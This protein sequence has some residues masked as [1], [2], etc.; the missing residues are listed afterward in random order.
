MGKPPYQF[1]CEP[2]KYYAYSGPGIE[3]L[4]GAIEELTGTDL[5][6]LAKEH[7]FDDV[8]MP[9]STYVTVLIPQPLMA[10]IA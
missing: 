1:Q 4:Q 10:L 7:V 9:L 5:E 6:I 8:G 3:C 2:G